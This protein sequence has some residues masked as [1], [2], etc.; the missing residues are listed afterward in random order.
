MGHETLLLKYRLRCP[1]C[2]IVREDRAHGRAGN[3][4]ELKCEEAGAALSL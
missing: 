3:H 1:K 4:S 2:K